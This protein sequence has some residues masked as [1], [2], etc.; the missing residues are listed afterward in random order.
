MPRS[1]WFT[2]QRSIPAGVNTRS[3]SG[4]RPSRGVALF[5]ARTCGAPGQDPGAPAQH[6]HVPEITLVDTPG[7]SDPGQVNGDYAVYTHCGK[8]TCNVFRYQ[9][10]TGQ[11]VKMPN[12]SARRVQYAPSVSA[13]GTVYYASSRF[14]CG[15]DVRIRRFV[16]VTRRL[17][18]DALPAGRTSTPPTRTT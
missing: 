9:I 2:H 18:D 7:L 13:D 12:A 6:R 4:G 17:A 10:S 3:G 14:A 16:V 11:R 8:V 15:K 1:T 5:G